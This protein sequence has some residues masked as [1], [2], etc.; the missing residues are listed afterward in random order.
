MELPR[1]PSSVGW[2]KP[3]RS[4]FVALAI[5][6]LSFGHQALVEAQERN[7]G[8]HRLEYY[9]RLAAVSPRD[10]EGFYALAGWCEGQGLKDE[11]QRCLERV[12]RVDPD[13]PQAREAL[14]YTRHGLGWR[15]GKA[16]G[17]PNETEAPPEAEASAPPATAPTPEPAAGEAPAPAPAPSPVPEAE[18]K[19][20]PAA[21]AGESS[22]LEAKRAFAKAAEEKLKQ[23]FNTKEDAD[24]IIHTTHDLA[25]PA[26]RDL[27]NVLKALKKRIATAISPRAGSAIWPD[28]VQIFF[29]SNAERCALFAELVDG[30]R[31]PERD[32]FYAKAGHLVFH[33][34]PEE[35]LALYLGETALERLD[36]SDRFVGWWLRFGLAESIASQTDEGQKNSRYPKAYELAASLLSGKNEAFSV[37][38][39]LETPAP[40]VRKADEQ[41]ALAL[42]FFDFLFQASK[43]RLQK[44][45]VDLK[46]PTAPAPPEN[47]SDALAFRKF[48]VEYL[49]YQEDLIVKGYR[50]SLEQLDQRWKAFIVERAKALKK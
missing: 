42:T 39:L 8:E 34:L 45:I 28:K 38:D 26:V 29:F 13:H 31:F 6:V 23:Q 43:S 47:Q 25:S 4:C 19:T 22:G 21:G 46:G 24:F 16:A 18:R 20:P 50:W 15:L 14:G 2:P 5:I 10:A 33:R 36:G 27:H 49:A 44:L 17:K 11:A 48:F 12:I 3:G 35:R 9:R 7:A 41:R 40:N 30:Q 32:G 37:A 1:N